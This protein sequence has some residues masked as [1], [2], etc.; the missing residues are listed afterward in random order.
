MLVLAMG[1]LCVGGIHVAVAVAV[2]AHVND[3]A[4]VNV[5]GLRGVWGWAR[6]AAERRPDRPPVLGCPPQ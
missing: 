2:N 1:R 5:F 3:N 6:V 4:H